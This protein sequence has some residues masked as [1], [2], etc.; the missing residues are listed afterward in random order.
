MLDPGVVMVTQ[1]HEAARHD[2]LRHLDEGGVGAG[3]PLRVLVEFH[4]A[5]SEVIA[6]S[7]LVEC[8]G[9]ARM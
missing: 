5:G 4:A 6:T 1:D 9:M 8:S 2:G 7:G 3:K